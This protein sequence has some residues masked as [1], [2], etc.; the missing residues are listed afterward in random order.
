MPWLR[1]AEAILPLRRKTAR[2]L[3]GVDTLFGERS[4]TN[5]SSLKKS[6]VELRARVTVPDP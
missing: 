1:T 5:S 6:C 2:N 3:S 4:L